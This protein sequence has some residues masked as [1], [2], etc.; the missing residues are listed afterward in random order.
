MSATE[1]FQ[2]TR[3]SKVGLC[4]V[5]NF[6]LYDFCE[7]RFFLSLT[8]GCFRRKLEDLWRLIQDLFGGFELFV[9]LIR[10]IGLRLSG[11]SKCITS[12][13]S[14]ATCSESKFATAKP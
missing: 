10:G 6:A 14:S 2:S 12:A 4:E 9:R 13:Q 11:K 8:I 7:N 1:N 5:D 3:A